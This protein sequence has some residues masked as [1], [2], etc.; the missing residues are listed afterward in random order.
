MGV[1]KQ[2]AA[3]VP[4][5]GNPYHPQQNGASA[6]PTAPQTARP[7]APQ[8]ARPAASQFPARPA[9]P[10]APA[11]RDG[12]AFADRKPAGFGTAP[13]RND[14]F[15]GDNRPAGFGA[16]PQNAPG[17]NDNKNRGNNDRNRFGA[18]K[19]DFSQNA[20]RETFKAQPIVRGASTNLNP[21]G[22]RKGASAERAC[23][24]AR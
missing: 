24:K 10:Q 5:T 13:A 18:D 17:R 2:P 15:G 20:P 9:A 11:R 21:D 4:Y 7:A 6:R 23:A 16:R 14:R 12:A 3:R 8:T 19:G 22:T 1:K